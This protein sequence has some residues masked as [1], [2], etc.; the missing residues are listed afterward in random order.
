LQQNF[1][2]ILTDAKAYV[3][4]TQDHQSKLNLNPLGV[5]IDAEFVFDPLKVSDANIIDQLKWLDNISF[6]GQGMGMEKWMFLDCAALP[7]AIFG[8]MVPSHYLPQHEQKKH[9]TKYVPITMMMAIP[10]LS[11]GEWFGHN[12]SSIAKQMN[13]PQKGWGLLTK[14]LGIECLSSFKFRGATQWGN[15]AISLHSSLAPLKL[16][17]VYTPGHSKTH[18]LCYHSEYSSEGL[19]QVLNGL[20]Q[21]YTADIWFNPHKDAEQLQNKI[22][23]GETFYLLAGENEKG[24]YPL[25]KGSL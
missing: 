4:V 9:S 10:T 22:E 7:S 1:S 6:G 13:L 5:T 16:L 3:V 14:L 20:A 2:D 15:P 24:E 12:L 18:T 21:D 11:P 23:Q 8:L 17:S 19:K 25:K